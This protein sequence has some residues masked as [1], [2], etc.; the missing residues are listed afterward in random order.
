M[1]MKLN[2]LKILFFLCNRRFIMIWIIHLILIILT[3]LA[4]VNSQT[5][6]YNYDPGNEFYNRIVYYTHIDANIR[7]EPKL[8]K[9][10]GDVSFT[11]RKL[12]DNYQQLKFYAPNFSI[13]QISIDQYKCDYYFEGNNLVVNNPIKL[14]EDKDYRINIKYDVQTYDGEIFFVGWNDLTNRRLKQIWSH[15]PHGWLPYADSRLTMDFKITFDSTYKV[16]TNGKRREIIKNNDG[17]LTW[18]YILDKEHP[19]FSTCVVIGPMDWITLKSKSGIEEELWFYKWERNK[20]ETTYQ[21]S[22]EMIDFLE[23]ELGVAYPYAIYKQAPVADYQYGGMETTTA[24]VFG[25]YMF[26]DKGAY[27]QRNYINVNV[28]E[29]VHQWYGNAITH[30]SNSNV[31]LTE[32]FATYYAK[33][34][35]KSIFGKDY[36]DWERTKE[37]EK[38]FDAAKRDNLPVASSIS[39]VER[40][41]QKGSL[42]MDMLRDVVGENDFRKAITHYTKK[43]L[44]GETTIE[45][46]QKAFHDVTGYDY[47]W[48]FEQWFRRGGEPFIEVSF[49]QYS[50]D[51]KK[52]VQIDV[53]QTH[54]TD[55][56]VKLFKIPTKIDLYF[57]NGSFETKSVVVEK[58]FTKFEFEIEDN[59]DLDFIV[60]DPDYR[61]LKQIK[62]NQSL[63]TTYKQATKSRFLLDRY[64]ALKSLEKNDWDKKIQVLKEIYFKETYHLLKSEVIRQITKNSDDP[65]SIEILKDACKNSDPLVVQSVVENIKM[66]PKE[67]KNEYENIL[68]NIS[69]K[70]VEL[71]LD[72]LANSF[73]DETKKYLKITS[74][75]EGWRGRNIRM[76]WL[77]LNYLFGNKKVLDQIIDY[78]SISF[79]FETRLNAFTILRNI[80]YLDKTTAHNLLLAS[81]HWNPKLFRPTREILQHFRK[82]FEYNKL[83]QELIENSKW[84]NWEN[85]KIKQI[86]N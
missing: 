81:I 51:N 16:F 84:T 77:E 48:F 45:D 80:N 50:K 83:I 23:K 33:L 59:Q 15:R 82:Q 7:F 58:K 60:F 75:M 27:W 26:I 11:F 19:F 8:N 61:I 30:I 31:F 35:E 74:Q 18:H 1:I 6:V 53:E 34:F 13:K 37:M 71:A 4:I 68:S 41:Y 21:Y 17:T 10:I 20:F 39:G 69:Y 65:I 52:Y 73:P 49:Q 22:T 72:N 62:Y 29:L 67:I 40:I 3:N 44:F 79:D 85:N 56:L 2:I 5:I 47:N 63:E 46:F 24:T 54:K 14:E 86:L 43:H 38:T 9:T 57:K 70:N 36:Y 32:S 66:I 64:Y 12:S 25:D 78:T 55:D 76:K 42:V 28:H